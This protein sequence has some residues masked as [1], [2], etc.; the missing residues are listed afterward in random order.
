MNWLMDILSST[1]QKTGR[2]WQDSLLEIIQAINKNNEPLEP[3][4][5]NFDREDEEGTYQYVLVSY[6]IEDAEQV[7][8]VDPSEEEE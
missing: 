8:L 2:E 3:L 4:F 7:G 5:T 1:S 6:R